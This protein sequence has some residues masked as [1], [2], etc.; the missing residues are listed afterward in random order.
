MVGLE[1]FENPHHSE[2][3][4]GRRHQIWCCPS[5]RQQPLGQLAD[6]KIDTGKTKWSRHEMSSWGSGAT[7][8]QTCLRND[9]DHPQIQSKPM[10]GLT[11]A[12][13]E[14]EANASPL[15]WNLNTHTAP[16][17][18]LAPLHQ[19][20]PPEEAWRF[21]HF[22]SDSLYTVYIRYVVLKRLDVLSRAHVPHV[23]LFVTALMTCEK[24]HVSKHGPRKCCCC[25]VWN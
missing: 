12:S 22:T 2:R 5:G 8:G 20:A 23:G 13:S 16:L 7:A 3:N 9:S 24:T 19:W 25:R 1:I 14:A 17:A 21:K 15:G 10:M 4:P 6:H 11:V 18:Q